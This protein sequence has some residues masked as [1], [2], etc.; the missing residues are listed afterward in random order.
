M[1]TLSVGTISTT[2]NAVTP[3][4]G[5]TMR[6]PGQVVQVLT[7][8]TDERT[9]YY[10][11]NSGNG[12]TIS[13]LNLTITPKFSSSLL[14][15][16]WMMNCE[17]HHDN[18]ILIHQNGSLITTS[19]YEGYNSGSGNQRWSGYA[20]GFYDADEGS[21]MVN[22]YLLYAIPAT[23][24]NQRTYAPAVRSSSGTNYVFTLNKSLGSQGQDDYENTVSTGMIME[25]QQ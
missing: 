15:M 20:S 21:T 11:P 17:V 7:I 25:I 2:G 9:A 3:T 22:F 12:T 19:G 24:L 1:S 13:E 18:V 4:S 5:T 6:Y 23:N 10:S 8:R 16:E 14:V